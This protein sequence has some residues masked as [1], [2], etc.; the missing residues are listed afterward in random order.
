MAICEIGDVNIVP[1]TSAIGSAVVVPE[2]S[3]SLA[4][5]D[6][7][8]LD[9]GEK[10]VRVLIGLI[11]KQIGL[12]SPARVEVP[13]GYNSPILVHT[14]QRAKQHLH[15]GFGLS[16]GAAW[17]FVVSFCAVVLVTVHSSSGG[18]DEVL[19]VSV[20]LHQFEQI[21][22]ANHVIFIVEHRFGKRFSNSLLGSKVHNS[23]DGLTLFQV[24]F[25]DSF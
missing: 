22:R 16:I 13:K 14:A 9:E 18:E 15:A 8:L 12:V 1:D 20:L 3:E 4:F 19:A 23:I 11:A 6:Y 10:V 2:D 25:E 24:L 17:Q 7:D 21:Y 5:L